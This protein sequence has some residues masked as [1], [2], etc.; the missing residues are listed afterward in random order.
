[1]HTQTP[2]S[3]ENVTAYSSDLVEVTNKTS[4]ITADGLESIAI[5]LENI[6]QVE[7]SSKEVCVCRYSVL[8]TCHSFE[9]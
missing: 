8:Y 4:S 1:M 6:V 5:S 9:E 7:D 3:A 2:I